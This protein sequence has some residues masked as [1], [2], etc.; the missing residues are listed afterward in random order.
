MG[1]D[2]ADQR[3][4]NL[5]LTRVLIPPEGND[6]G[7]VI[8]DKAAEASFMAVCPLVHPQFETVWRHLP[9][10]SESRT[11]VETTLAHCDRSAQPS[12]R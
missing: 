11:G 9:E 7:A 3:T 6:W 4:S 2:G 10:G 12:S 8:R 1:Q 5:E